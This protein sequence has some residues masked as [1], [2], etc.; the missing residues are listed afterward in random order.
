MKVYAVLVCKGNSPVVKINS[1]CFT[2]LTKAH[3]FI[4]SRADRP[5]DLSEWVYKSDEYWYSIHELDI[6]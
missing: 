6:V 3:D 1:E 4:E 2:S 5:K